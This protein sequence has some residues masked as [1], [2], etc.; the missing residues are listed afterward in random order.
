MEILLTLLKRKK[1]LKISKNH[2]RDFELF[3]SEKTS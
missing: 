2:M 1:S 3:F